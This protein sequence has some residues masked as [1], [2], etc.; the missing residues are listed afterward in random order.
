MARVLNYIFDRGCQTVVL[1]KLDP[2]KK[3]LTAIRQWLVYRVPNEVYVGGLQ[4]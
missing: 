3:M 2:Q 1:Q 4:D